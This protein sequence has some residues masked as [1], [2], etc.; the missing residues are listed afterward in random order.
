MH[1]QVSFVNSFQAV[2]NKRIGQLHRYYLTCDVFTGYEM[3]RTRDSESHG[4]P[5]L[6][7]CSEGSRKTITKAFR[8]SEVGHS[9]DGRPPSG[10]FLEEARM[11]K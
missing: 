6:M 11:A 3:I 1:R 4:A 7:C 2:G 10:L 5:E 8:V 9:Q